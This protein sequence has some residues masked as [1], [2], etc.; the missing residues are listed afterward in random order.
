MA[1]RCKLGDP[2]L[3]LGRASIGA[4]SVQA[5]VTDLGPAGTIATGICFLDH[6]IDQLTSHAQIG[7][8]LCANVEGLDMKPRE[9][10]SS[11]YSMAVRPHDK[12]IFEASGAALGGAL[13]SLVE[14]LVP[15]AAKPSARATF[16]CPLDE[17]LAEAIL[18]LEAAAPKLTFALAP[19]GTRPKAGREWIGRYRT[20][21][22]EVFWRGLV[23][24]LRAD[25]SLRK[26]RGDNAHH[27]VESAFKAFSRALR[28]SL[29]RASAVVEPQCGPA[30][31]GAEAPAT[32][33]QKTLG[34][35]SARLASRSRSTKETSIEVKVDLDSE[36]SEKDTISTG[37][38]VLDS[39]LADLRRS[40]GFAIAVR[41]DGDRYIDDHHTTEDVSITLG[42]CLHEALGDK[43]GLARMAF[44][45]VTHGAA[46]VR[47]VVDLS[48]RPHFECDLELDEEFVG[49]AASVKEHDDGTVAGRLLSCEMLLHAFESL[50]LE[51][52]ATVHLE[53]LARGE[54]PGYTLE[55]ALAAARAYGAALGAC[56]TVDPRRAGKVASSKGTLSV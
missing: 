48:N 43:K 25:L 46:R 44:A 31:N 39:V 28:A 52:R 9:D 4:V 13:L 49:G 22:T 53:Q 34:S 17:A 20:E 11:A 56:A 40:S 45:D 37:V 16:C 42:Q 24:T 30:A 36:T 1:E 23:G 12:A 15:P 29:D 27:I 5:T 54:G 21:L 50:A 47:V 19:Y 55:L 6:M 51:A 10:Y 7:T 32:K 8:S 35:P 33:R 41:C 2:A 26:V 18:E 38:V 14:S 3:H